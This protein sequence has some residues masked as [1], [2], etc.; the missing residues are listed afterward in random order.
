MSTL[1]ADPTASDYTFMCVQQG[2]A[3]GLNCATLTATGVTNWLD[4]TTST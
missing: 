3:P 1:I 4:S 2:I